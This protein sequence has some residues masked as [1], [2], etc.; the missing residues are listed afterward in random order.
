MQCLENTLRP[1]YVTAD[2]SVLGN[3]EIIPILD[4]E[5]T[6]ARRGSGQPARDSSA[7]RAAASV[8]GPESRCRNAL[9]PAACRG[10]SRRGRRGTAGAGRACAGLRTGPRAKPERGDRACVVGL[11]RALWGGVAELPGWTLELPCAPPTALTLSRG[12]S[13]PRARSPGPWMSPSSPRPAP[14]VPFRR[15]PAPPRPRTASGAG[16]GR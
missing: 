6:E 2:Y 13:A 1:K 7:L 14:P 10:Q 15:L 5:K 9:P 11:R 3:N 8:P 16:A 4:T 12:A